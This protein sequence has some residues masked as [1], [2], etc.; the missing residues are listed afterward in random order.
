MFMAMYI[1]MGNVYDTPYLLSAG[2][3]FGDQESPDRYFRFLKMFGYSTVCIMY[4]DAPLNVIRVHII[5]K[6]K[7]PFKI[8]CIL[9][10]V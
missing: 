3:C 4:L 5:I 9:P 10:V 2:Y 7:N 1:Y 6:S 8:I